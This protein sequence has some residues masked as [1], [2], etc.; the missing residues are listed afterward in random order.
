MTQST[1]KALSSHLI[2][3]IA[4][5]SARAAFHLPLEF[6]KL[7]WSSQLGQK[8]LHNHRH[9]SETPEVSQKNHSFSTPAETFLPLSMNVNTK[10]AWDSIFDSALWQWQTAC[11]TNNQLEEDSSSDVIMRTPSYSKDISSLMR[12]SDLSLSELPKL[13]NTF[14]LPESLGS[15]IVLHFPSD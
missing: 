7:L 2:L 8:H 3:L 6:R 9:V 1:R 14:E 10:F 11:F 12:L 5:A 13:V 4:S 15:K